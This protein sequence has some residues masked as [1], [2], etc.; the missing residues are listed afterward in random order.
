MAR[1]SPEVAAKLD[2]LRTLMAAKAVDRLV[3]AT[4]P[5]YAWL[6]GGGDN[7]VTFATDRGVGALLVDEAGVHLLTNNIEAA[8]LVE[9]QLPGLEP[10]SVTAVNWFEDSL[11]A[12][13]G[14]LGEEAAATG[15]RVGADFA[16]SGFLDLSAEIAALRRPFVP[17]EVERFRALAADLSAV[18]E[19]AAPRI[20][21]GLTEW[22]VAALLTAEATAR[23]CQ[24][25]GVLVGAD[26]RVFARRHPL[27]VGRRIERYVLMGMVVQRGGLHCSLSRA[28]HFGPV[29]GELKAR[30]EAVD[31]VFAALLGASRPGV[32]LAE[33]LAAAEEAY[34]AAGFPGEW[35]FH[36]QGGLIG[37]LPRES[38]AN[39]NS[40]VAI[41]A[42]CGL[43]WNPTLQGTKCE[44]T[45]L[46]TEGG[47]VLLTSTPS[48]PVVKRSAGGREVAL[49][50]ILER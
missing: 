4:L 30:Q 50:G 12:L 31:S 2:R 41:E 40:T 48:W 34:A 24:V 22:E 14:R 17:A 6:S 7:H 25:P 10:D 13:L 21:P 29:P 23:G 47:P 16:G 39:P 37:Y 15:R 45:V 19:A 9:E 11:P 26:E 3:L 36:H 42:G 28:I 18:F 38:V 44:E 49:A 46:V 33:A 1:V 27:M 35:R 32:A 5:N 8:R 43:A 20:A